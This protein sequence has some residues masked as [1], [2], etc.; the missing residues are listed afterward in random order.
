MSANG[1]DRM[2]LQ[3][4]S[5]KYPF[6]FQLPPDTP[7]SFEGHWGRVRYYVKATMERTWIFDYKLTSYFTVLQLLDL[8]TLPQATVSF[9][10]ELQAQVNTCKACTTSQRVSRRSETVSHR[11]RN[12]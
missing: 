5:Y 9:L 12:K 10:S 6:Q 2:L 8:N 4:G 11:Y 7:S 3:P 1:E